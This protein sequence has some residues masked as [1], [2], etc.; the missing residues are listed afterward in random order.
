MLGDRRFA[1]RCKTAGEYAQKLPNCLR[2]DFF[3]AVKKE[4]DPMSHGFSTTRL[5]ME[6]V[7]E[8]FKK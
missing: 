1:L 3:N 8:K 2:Y 6:K 7:I 5:G 4:E